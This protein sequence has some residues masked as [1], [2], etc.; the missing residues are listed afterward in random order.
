MTLVQNWNFGTTGTIPDIDTMS[1]VFQYHD[2]FGT[3]NNGNGNYGADT[4]A[5][6][7]ATAL[8][9]QP[10]EDPSNPVRAFTSKSLQTYLV[11]L[12]GAKWVKPWEHNAGCGSFVSQYTLPNGGALLGQN[13]LWETRVRYK[14]PPYF[15]FAIWTSGNIWQNGA[16]MDVIESF[17]YNNGGGNTNYKGHYWHSDSVGGQDN[18]NYSGW[19]TGMASVGITSYNAAEYH[20]WQW[21]YHTD[22]TYQVLVD[23]IT[24]Q[25]GTI[26][27]TVGGVAGGTPINMTFLFDGGW[28]HTQVSSVDHA[29]PASQFTGRL[30]EWD[31]SRIY[32]KA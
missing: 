6:N 2:Q 9:G 26:H 25:S 23:G 8:P 3:Y 18:V 32:L 7:A 4:V 29:M 11:P 1:S 27:W 10:I 31:Y 19:S 15:W 5:P 13:L 21:R 17:G 14:T 24:V 16:E 20:T 22:D 28:G 12:N 30:Y